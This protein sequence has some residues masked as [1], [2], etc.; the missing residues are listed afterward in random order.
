MHRFTSVSIVLALAAAGAAAQSPYGAGGGMS[1]PGAGGAGN[2]GARYTTSMEPLP[3]PED[4]AGP[5]VPDF[6]VDRF[7]LDSAEAGAYRVVFDSFMTATRPLRDSAQAL[8][9]RIDALWQAGARGA[10][11]VQFPDLR[12]M[13]D[14]LSK[15][16]DRFDDRLKKVFTK[17]HYKD[18]RDWRSD[19]KR[20]ADQDRKDRMR[21]MGGD[22]PSGG[23]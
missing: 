5:G 16:D 11:R 15:E 21:Q 19:Q 17:P 9:R 3:S 13:G 8:R 23:P 20:Q 1:R 22:A 6:V 4:L 18:Y 12:R 14:A 2:G 10:A 7:E